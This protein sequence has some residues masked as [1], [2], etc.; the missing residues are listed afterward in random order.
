[1][2]HAEQTV[3]IVTPL[4]HGPRRGRGARRVA[5]QFSGRRQLPRRSPRRPGRLRRSV[6]PRKVHS[7]NTRRREVG[8]PWCGRCGLF[9]HQKV[10]GHEIMVLDDV[11]YGVEQKNK[12]KPKPKA[13]IWRAKCR[14]GNSSAGWRNAP[15]LNPKMRRGPKHLAC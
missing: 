4:L 13:P 14:R 2:C 3:D 9:L 7:S 8:G 15:A 6:L 11:D 5:Q 1:M 10:L 12:Q